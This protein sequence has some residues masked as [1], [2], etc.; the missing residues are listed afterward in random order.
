MYQENHR[1]KLNKL[2]QLLNILQD[3]INKY[4]EI[5]LGDVKYNEVIKS[6]EGHIKQ[7]TL[8]GEL[9]PGSLGSPGGTSVAQVQQTN[10]GSTA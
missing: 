8:K 6:I 5:V 7:I 4:D 10:P 2:N 9:D 1:I 3:Y